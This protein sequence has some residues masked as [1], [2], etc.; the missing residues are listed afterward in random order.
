MPVSGLLTKEQRKSLP[1]AIKEDE[2]SHF[3]EHVLIMLLA[4]DGKTQQQIADFGG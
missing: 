1:K 3:R 4:N 2:C